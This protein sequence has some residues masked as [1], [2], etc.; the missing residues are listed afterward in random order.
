MGGE[1]EGDT[2]R[3]SETDNHLSP[4][5]VVRFISVTLFIIM[6]I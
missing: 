3:F 4:K 6:I 5:L 1:G 2:G